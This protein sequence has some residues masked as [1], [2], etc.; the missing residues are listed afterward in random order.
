MT[1]RFNQAEQHAYNEAFDVFEA[2]MKGAPSEGNPYKNG[3]RLH[4]AWAEG[5]AEA[6]EQYAAARNRYHYETRSDH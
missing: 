6:R 2:F 5:Y 4:A 1:K 3:L